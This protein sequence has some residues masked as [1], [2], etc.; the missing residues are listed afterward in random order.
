MWRWLTRLNLAQCT[1]SSGGLQGQQQHSNAFARARALRYIQLDNTLCTT[2]SVSVPFTAQVSLRSRPFAF[3]RVRAVKS[4]LVRAF[5]SS[6]SMDKKQLDPDI[7]DDEAFVGME[8]GEL[9]DGKVVD[10]LNDEGAFRHR[11]APL[12]ASCGRDANLT[13]VV[14]VCSKCTVH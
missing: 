1:V 4:L 9:L 14:K 7:Y 12:V 11:S 8:E 5:S 10:D 6:H 3:A 2:L 13:M